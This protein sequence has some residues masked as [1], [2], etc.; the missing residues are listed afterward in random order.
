[1]AST[2]TLKLS[3][4]LRS[5]VAVLAK[6]SGRSAHS[7]MLE[8][9]ERHTAREERTRE[10]VKAAL[11][12]DRTIERG[13]EVYAAADVHAWLERLA[14]GKKPARPKPWRK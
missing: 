11:A 8:A 14:K 3:P 7:L 5:R 12:A 10:F 13:G 2:T 6:K 1:M 9:I 4:E